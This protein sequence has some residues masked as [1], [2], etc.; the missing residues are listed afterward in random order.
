MD[1]RFLKRRQRID[2]LFGFLIAIMGM[3]LLPDAISTL[4]DAYR[5]E[6]PET[7]RT[8]H[9]QLLLVH[10]YTGR[11]GD[12]SYYIDYIYTVGALTVRVRPCDISRD[13]WQALQGEDS[14]LMVKYLIADPKVSEP[15]LPGQE[16]F[17]VTN[18]WIFVC[19]SILLVALGYWGAL[20]SKRGQRKEKRHHPT[21]VLTKPTPHSPAARPGGRAGRHS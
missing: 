13:N 14:S 1:F 6:N 11:R 4:R 8:T 10:S 12:T 21:E 7:T 16:G 17:A 9:G 15:V 3:A 5:L 19:C 18:G 2:L 20:F